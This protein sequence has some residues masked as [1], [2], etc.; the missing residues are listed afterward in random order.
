[1]PLPKLKHE[2][3]LEFLVNRE[4]IYLLFCAII[5]DTLYQPY[6]AIEK[7]YILSDFL[8]E[9]RPKYESVRK[10]E[11][12]FESEIE[13]KTNPKIYCFLCKLFGEEK[14]SIDLFEPIWNEKK[15]LLEKE[16]KF[17]IYSEFNNNENK[18]IM[19]I[20]NKFLSDNF[21]QLNCIIQNKK[22][23]YFGNSLNIPVNY[24]Y[25]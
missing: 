14:I 3:T 10:F 4:I 6:R 8:W 1:M 15:V 9:K 23:I 13:F 12:I 21:H 11:F 7:E 16:H 5:D 22:R 24:N 20:S 25:F 2:G 17:I 19:L 18:F